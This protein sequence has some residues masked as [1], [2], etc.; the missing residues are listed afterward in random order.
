MGTA[1]AYKHYKTNQVIDVSDR[2]EILD[3]HSKVWYTYGDAQ[4]LQR[5]TTQQAKFLNENVGT[6]PLV[7]V[8]ND[9]GG[10]YI[11]SGYVDENYVQI[12]E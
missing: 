3:G 2:Q 8:V 10:R 12:N 5:Q 11:A 9:Q 4:S 1:R 6:N 7:A